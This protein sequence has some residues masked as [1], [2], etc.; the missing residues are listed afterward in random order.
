MTI[1]SRVDEYVARRVA[2]PPVI[3]R[4]LKS[5]RQHN[6]RISAQMAMPRQAEAAGQRIDSR[7]YATKARVVDCWR[8]V[9]SSGEDGMTGKDNPVCIASGKSNAFKTAQTAYPILLKTLYALRLPRS[10]GRS[11]EEAN[12]SN[13]SRSPRDWMGWLAGRIS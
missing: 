7:P 10:K 6:R 1:Q 9:Q 5:T 12:A 2:Y 8:H 13:F 4:F 3:S 11:G